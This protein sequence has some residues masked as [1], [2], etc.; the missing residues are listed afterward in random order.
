MFRLS[1]L[2]STLAQ[3]FF[4]NSLKY[5]QNA[6]R[7]DRRERHAPWVSMIDR[8]GEQKARVVAPSRVGTCY[9]ARINGLY[10]FILGARHRD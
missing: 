5:A 9:T 8:G 10:Y 6:L 4:V 7:A 3:R 2:T 1:I